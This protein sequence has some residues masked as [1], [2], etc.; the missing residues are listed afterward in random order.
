LETI[1]EKRGD[2]IAASAIVSKRG[3]G[4]A[5]ALGLAGDEIVD[6]VGGRGEFDAMAAQTRELADR[7]GEVGLADT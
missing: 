7:V 4:A 2:P 6:E 5:A 3:Q 1:I